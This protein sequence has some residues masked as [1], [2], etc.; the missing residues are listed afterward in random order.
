MNIMLLFIVQAPVMAEAY[1]LHPEGL[2]TNPGTLSSP[3][4]TIDKVNH[5]VLHP[6]D[7][8]L[9]HGGDTFTGALE[10]TNRGILNKD[11]LVISSYG[12]GRAVI[13]GGKGS[14]ILLEACRNLVLENLI[15]TGSGRLTG[16]T[17]DG[18]IM[19]NCSDIKVN[20]LDIS[21][22]QHSGLLVSGVTENIDIQ[23]I[24]AHDNGFA[25]IHVYGPYPEK[26]S[27][28]NLYIGYCKA[29]NNPGDPT[30]LNNHSGNGILVGV[31]DS[32]LIEYCEALNN[33]WDM[34]RKGNGPVGI[35]AWH[36]DHVTIQH[37]IS[38]NNKTSSGSADG[39]GFDLDGGVTNSVVQYCLSY[40]NQGAGFGLFEYQGA[41]DFADNSI[42]Y[43]ISIND[44]TNYGGA[45]AA[46]WNGQTDNQ[47]LRNL[48]F[49]NNVLYNDLPGGKA[50]IFWSPDHSGFFFCNNI[51]LTSGAAISGPYNA[52]DFTG[53]V[54]WN[55]GKPFNMEGAASFTDWARESGKEIIK[56]K[57]A[58][59]NID[60]MLYDPGEV[61]I[62]DPEEINFYSLRGFQL[63]PGS[64]LRDKGLDLA[65]ILSISMGCF[66]FF[67]DSIPVGAYD[68]GIHE[69]RN[70]PPE[71]FSVPDTQ[72]YIGSEYRYQV[73][74]SDRDAADTVTIALEAGPAWLEYYPATRQ[75]AGIPRQE[76]AGRD[77]VIVIASDCNDTVRQVFVLVVR[78][79][80]HPPSGL[81]P[82]LQEQDPAQCFIFPNPARRAETISLSLNAVFAITDASILITDIS[83]KCFFLQNFKNI[84]GNKISLDLKRSAPESGLY[85]VTLT[86]DNK[87]E[88]CKLIL[89]Q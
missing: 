74:V 63:R 59:M 29:E 3:W 85:Q 7:S 5:T 24:N 6:G 60:P 36:A 22:F 51:F 65:Q 49:H 42:R 4:K 80:Y 2:D 71:I 55:F 44:G 66:D 68:I 52:A 15:I 23:R 9:F 45:G 28:K 61:D 73:N 37:C 57:V 34:P 56:G 39:G 62:T 87:I 35:W 79:E 17:E 53:N 21:G 83:G 12:S 50:I 84:R 11:A 67:G 89:Y 72:V 75:L 20:N 76:D 26:T 86:Y 8:L 18:V 43:N 25:G 19:N 47:K 32:V 81:L 54:Y 58:G 33:G 46:V 14:G 69:Y 70:H 40:E 41:Y 27:C 13:S 88:T 10:M 64:P 77:T 82:D 31:C 30:V 48:Y 16:N 78:D 38:H 1:Y